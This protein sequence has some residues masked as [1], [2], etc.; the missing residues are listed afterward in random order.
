VWGG[1]SFPKRIGLEKKDSPLGWGEV[2]EKRIQCLWTLLNLSFFHGALSEGLP[3]LSKGG[4]GSHRRSTGPFTQQSLRL[5]MEG[6][7]VNNSMARNKNT[8][9]KF[10]GK[11]AR[12]LLELRK[13]SYGHRRGSGGESAHKRGSGGKRSIKWKVKRN[14]NRLWG[15]GGAQ[16]NA[17]PNGMSCL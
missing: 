13:F 16:K 6:G 17:Q 9:N 10:E 11:R 2:G 15:S 8:A 14:V 7:R 5:A 3:G 4:E 12:N 1:W